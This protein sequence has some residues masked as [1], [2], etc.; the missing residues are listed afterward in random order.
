M[1]ALFTAGF[2]VQIPVYSQEV[3]VQDEQVGEGDRLLAA[4]RN[5]TFG[6][7][8]TPGASFGTGPSVWSIIR[9]LLVLALA[10]AAIYGAVFFIKRTTKPSFSSDPFL[11]I[12]A[13][14][15][16]GSNRY[17]HVVHVGNKAWLIGSGEGGVN[18]IGEVDDKETIDAMLLDDSRRSAQV[19]RGNLPNFLSALKKF[20]APVED[21]TTPGAD[22]IRRRRERLEGL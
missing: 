22:E 15:H 17:V 21:K 4:E 20:G 12:L 18:A 8:Q 6:E 3:P 9:M 7:T 16:L 11:K 1:A 14:H 10:A 2:L 5:L 13:S 19:L